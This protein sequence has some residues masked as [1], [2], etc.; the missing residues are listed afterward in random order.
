[1]SAP[2]TSGAEEN[3]RVDAGA[4]TALT[5]YL[6]GA[7]HGAQPGFSGLDQPRADILRTCIRCGYCLPSCPTYLET[8]NEASSPRGRIRL[9]Q[10]VADGVLSVTDP[11]FV[12]QM[13]HC[14]DCRA[15]E[16]VCPSAV[17]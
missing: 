3:T 6:F 8:F 12:E 11:G 17:R 15:C 4:E 9:I 13:S 10:A 2:I 7:K 1:M 5:P 16:A 14:L